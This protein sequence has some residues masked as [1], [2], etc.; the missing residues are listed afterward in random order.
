MHKAELLVWIADVS[1]KRDQWVACIS[2][3]PCVADTGLHTPSPAWACNRKCELERAPNLVILTV[4]IMRHTPIRIKVVFT[5]VIHISQDTD[6]MI[7][8]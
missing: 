3:M 7:R 8:G 2:M 5:T 1:N 4:S 6:D